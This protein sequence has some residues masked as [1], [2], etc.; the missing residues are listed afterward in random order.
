[1]HLTN[2]SVNKFASNFVHNKD[3]EDDASGSK[4]SLTAFRDYL[5]VNGINSAQ[6]FDRIEELAVKTILSIENVTNNAFE[7]NVPYR[8]NCFE[9][10]GFDILIDS[11]LK[12]GMQ[13]GREVTAPPRLTF[14]DSLG[15][16]K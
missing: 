4:W 16:W 11:N 3:A 2:Y 7:I 9:L 14:V 1:M 10:F 12:V 5:N 8:N 6:I 13:V 15:S